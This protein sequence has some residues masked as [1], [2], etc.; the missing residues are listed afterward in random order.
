MLFCVENATAELLSLSTAMSICPLPN[1]VETLASMV[2][3][4]FE[5]GPREQCAGALPGGACLT[6][7]NGRFR[8]CR[9]QP[10]LETTLTGSAHCGITTGLAT[11]MPRF[12]LR[13]H[14]GDSHGT[15]RHLGSLCGRLGVT[16]VLDRDP[17]ISSA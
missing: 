1:E 15:L 8:G 5:E 4:S 10:P 2:S 14:P 7:A 16:P 9:V 6:A 13:P 3:S 11:L 12:S 17:A